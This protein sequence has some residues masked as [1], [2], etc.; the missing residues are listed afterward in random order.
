[1][2][3]SEIVYNKI[4]N[5]LKTHPKKHGYIVAIA[6]KLHVSKQYIHSIIKQF[7]IPPLPPKELVECRICGELFNSKCNIK[8]CLDC[9]RLD[10]LKCHVCGTIGYEIA[11]KRNY[12]R[13]L[14]CYKDYEKKAH[15][16][17]S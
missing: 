7:K 9:K 16:E 10:L 12:G 6:K 2:K 11:F 8:T 1:M 13:C 17:W 4:L 5:Y 14:I 15:Q 3:Q